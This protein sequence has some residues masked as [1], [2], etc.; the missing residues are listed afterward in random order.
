MSVLLLTPHDPYEQRVRGALGPSVEVQRIDALVLGE[1]PRYAV[2]MII[3]H[4][5]DPEVVF[6]GPE[7]DVQYALDYA[8]EFDLQRPDV[9]VIV[10]APAS[11][12]V[13]GEA[14]HAGVRDVVDPL[15]GDDRILDAYKRA[16]EAAS[17]ARSRVSADER[18]ADPGGRVIAVVSPKGGSGKTTVSTNLAVGLANAAPGQVA[19]VDLDLQFGDVATALQLMPE[20]NIADA[21][22]AVST[23]DTMSLKVLLTHHT[24]DFYALCAPDSPAEG[25]RV[26][27]TQTGSILKLLQHEFRYTVIDTAAGLG[28]QTLTALEAATDV[29]LICAMD[30]PGVRSF[31]TM[32][33]TLDE[34]GMTTALRQVVLTRADSRVGLNVEDIER[35]VGRSID[36]TIPSTRAVP[37]SINQGTPILQSDQRRTPVYQALQRLTAQFADVPAKGAKGASES[38]LWRRRR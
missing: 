32:L 6:I 20:H 22:R 24:L 2:P 4:Y 28:E 25:E 15:S 21:A 8:Y 14:L 9:S 1:D 38:R 31:R 12:D 5:G 26:S 37:L 13:L 35:T 34:I 29:V 30:V 19:I 18:G 7:I 16:T 17:R 11:A 23:L 10:V 36:V 27:A 3:E 33:H